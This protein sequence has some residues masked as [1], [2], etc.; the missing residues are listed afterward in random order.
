[1]RKARQAGAFSEEKPG[2]TKRSPEVKG[3]GD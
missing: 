2:R 3:S 1:V